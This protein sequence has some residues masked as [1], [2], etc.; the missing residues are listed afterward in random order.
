MDLTQFEKRKK[1]HLEHA[2]VSKHQA[3]GLSGLDQIVLS[4]EALPEIDFS[5]IDLSSECLGYKTQVP[6]YISG[7]T[8]GHGS[9]FEINHVLAKACSQRGWAMGVGSQRREL[10]DSRGVDRWKELRAECPHLLLFSNLGISQLILTPMPKIQ[11]L[12]DKIQA[13]ALVVHANALQECL[14][15]EG[16]PDFKGGLRK[17][18]EVCQNLSVPVVLKETGCGFSVST[19]NRLQEIG[20]KALD[21]SGLGGTHWGR[22]EGT[23]VRDQDPLDVRVRAS[24]TF[25]NWG[26]STVQSVLHAKNILHGVEIWASGGVRSGLDAA[27][28]LALGA[29]HVGYAQPALQAALQGEEVLN[30]WMEIQE[31]ELKVAL[32]CTGCL[33]REEL[34][35]KEGIWTTIEI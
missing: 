12:V 23:R 27:K 1:E 29:C 13:Q 9:S 25:S 31:F 14:Q 30:R 17:L 6:F 3:S 19:L 34:K 33:N 20:L 24:E 4:H 32:F 16:T 22:I 26:I 35:T 8:A 7:M 18:K 2:L 10:E 11:E 15:K 28:L 21:V 5:T